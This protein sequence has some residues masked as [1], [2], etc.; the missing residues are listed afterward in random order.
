MNTI[1]KESLSKSMAYNEFRNLVKDLLLKGK[2]T[3]REQT[4][5]LL[6][7][8]KLNDSRM[9]RL[10]KTTKLSKEV[11]SLTKNLKNKYTWIVL[12]EGW[13]GDAA[14]TLPVINKIAE[15]SDNI[16]LKIALR[17]DNEDL[18]NQFLTNGNKS[19]PKLIAID[20]A[21]NRVIAD[22]GPRPSIAADMV[23]NYKKEHGGLDA[24]FKKDLQIWYNKN[25]GE[26]TQED[27]LKLLK[28]S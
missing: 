5:S 8:S 18:M 17:D 27:I 13:C 28:A 11:I 19:I 2:S 4:E 24:E 22:W 1:I 16:D 3:G 20:K 25:K 26:N 9:K 14:Q 21:S 15:S 12:T 6:N 7:Y 23:A 10:D